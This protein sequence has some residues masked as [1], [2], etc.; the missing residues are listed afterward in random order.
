L[1]AAGLV[2][3]WAWLMLALIALTMM[4]RRSAMGWEALGDLEWLAIFGNG[5]GS[6]CHGG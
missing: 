4:K 3:S 6:R 5:Y 1:G 2:V